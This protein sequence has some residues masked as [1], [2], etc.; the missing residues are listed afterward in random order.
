MADNPETQPASLV[1]VEN[2][3]VICHAAIP[4][5]Y[6][7]YGART[8]KAFGLSDAITIPFYRQQGFGLKRRK[9]LIHL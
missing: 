1:F 6:I 2:N 7:N 4:W 9:K 3:T 8:Y 5:K